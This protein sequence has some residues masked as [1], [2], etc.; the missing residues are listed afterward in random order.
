VEHH[1]AATRDDYVFEREVEPF[2]LVEV[3]RQIL[4]VFPKI[5]LARLSR[6]KSGHAQG[7]LSF[8][9]TLF[10]DDEDRGRYEDAEGE[11]HHQTART[12][13]DGSFELYVTSLV[14]QRSSVAAL[15][16]AIARISWG[17]EHSLEGI[18]LEERHR[19][20]V[21]VLLGK[22]FRSRE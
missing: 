11:N 7:L 3:R 21:L 5:E 1:I 8:V 14:A 10:T 13:E 2:D 4:G 16:S 18:T 15:S 19:T 6:E 20:L 17:K 9:I 12:G 22:A